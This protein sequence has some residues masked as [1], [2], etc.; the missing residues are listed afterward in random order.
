VGS[1]YVKE[2]SMSVFKKL[3]EDI[4]DLAELNVNTFTGELKAV[5]GGSGATNIIKWDEL[6]EKAAAGGEVTLVASTRQKLDG[7]S[8]S[9]Y[10]RNPPTDLLETHK[11]AVEAGRQVR[12]GLIEMFGD[13]VGLTVKK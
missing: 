10:T 8:D 7:D 1:T 6:L 3:A 13:L 11:Q 2:M 4:A 12:R 5:V 9:F